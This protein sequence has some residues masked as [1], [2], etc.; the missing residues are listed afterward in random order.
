MKIG[1]LS[2]KY[3]TNY[4]GILQSLALQRTLES[5][6][7]EV[8]II[9]F[10]STLKE[11]FIHRLIFRIFN[12]LFSKNIFAT[13][14]D[15][16]KE[17]NKKTEK[18]PDTLIE[19]C[20][21]FMNKYLN[22][23]KLVDETTISAYCRGFDCIIVGSDQIWSVTNSSKLIYFFDWQFTGKKIS[24]AACSV[25]KKP[26]FLNRPKIKRLLK[27]FNA[28]SVRDEVTRNFVLSTSETSP[29]IV[30]DPTFLYNFDSILDRR[31]IKDP[32]ILTYI[33]GDEIKGGNKMAIKEIKK[34]C[35][36]NTKVISIV[37]PSVSMAGADIA[38]ILIKD[39]DPAKWINLIKFAEFIYTDSFHGV[40]FSI[41]YKKRFI[42]YYCYAKRATR[43]IDLNNRYDIGNII[44][45]SDKIKD[46]LK[47]DHKPNYIK[48]EEHIKESK[49]F[50]HDKI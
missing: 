20:E 36:E 34:K 37:I 3:K 50:L 40:V 24:Y 38:D 32:Y 25:N 8:E 44:D 29:V 5:L 45:H 23:G 42:G 48:I 16:R 7:H 28:V 4:G 10:S 39:A 19:N 21:S 9:N 2:L 12:L 22:R 31:I 49:Q 33:L 11:G 13:I 26:A 47:A 14:K 17:Q 18:D 30:S 27:T 46:I 35:P 43:L 6:G 1:I 41:K 15:S